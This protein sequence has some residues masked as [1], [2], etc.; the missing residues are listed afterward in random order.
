DFRLVLFR[1][2]AMTLLILP[3]PL[4]HLWASTFRK[5][6]ANPFP[7]YCI[8]DHEKSVVLY[9][10]LPFILCLLPGTISNFSGILPSKSG[11]TKKDYGQDIFNSGCRYSK[12]KKP[13]LGGPDNPPSPD[14]SCPAKQ[15]FF[16]RNRGYRALLF[17]Q[18]GKKA[19]ILPGL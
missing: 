12:R 14:G 4:R 6:T 7:L 15:P 1:S 19:P 13:D 9:P 8:P 3:P 2:T 16:D 10:L 5:E 17:Q 11:D 18:G